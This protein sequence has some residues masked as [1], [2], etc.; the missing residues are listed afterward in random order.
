MLNEV[1]L[2]EQLNDIDVAMKEWIGEAVK[3]VVGANI[4]TIQDIRFIRNIDLIAQIGNLAKD[5]IIDKVSVVGVKVFFSLPDIYS[6]VNA[7]PKELNLTLRSQMDS[8]VKYVLCIQK[9]KAKL[10]LVYPDENI[11][12]AEFQLSVPEHVY[13]GNDLFW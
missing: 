11:V 2:K 5:I 13:R 1:T 10:E 8:E 12:F 3:E 9:T 7:M 4:S 6:G